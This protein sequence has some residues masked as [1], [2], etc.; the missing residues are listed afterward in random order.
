MTLGKPPRLDRI[1]QTCDP[2]LFFVTLCT[3]RRQK[4]LAN[5]GAHTA[6]LDYAKRGLDHNVTVGRYVVKPDHIHLFVAGD[7]EFDL[8]IWMRG[9]KRVVAAAVHR[10]QTWKGFCRWD[11][12]GYNVSSSGEITAYLATRFF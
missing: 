6:F 2:P 9:L 10:R 7:H 3:A 8:G 5:A 4:V 11:S 1:F 12:G